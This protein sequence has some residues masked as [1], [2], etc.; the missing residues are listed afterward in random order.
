MN[1]TQTFAL[2][3]HI[4]HTGMAHH[5]RVGKRAPFAILLLLL[6]AA[7]ATTAQP[8]VITFRTETGVHLR[9][10][11][12]RQPGFAGYHVERKTAGGQWN[13]LTTTPLQRATTQQEIERIAGF[14]TDLYLTLFDAA[15]PPRDLTAAD[16]DRVLSRQNNGLFEAICVV[17]SEFG[18]LLGELY[19]DS[20]L[21]AGSDAEYR[22]TAIVGGAERELGISNPVGTE[23][24]T[25]PPVADLLGE[26]GDRS[27]T[28]RWERDPELQQQGQVI[29]WNIYRAENVLGPF[30]QINTT[31]L[32]PINVSSDQSP[33]DQNQQTF[34]DEYLE[35]G[36][37]YFYHIRA[38]NPFGIEGQPSVTVEITTG[39][40]EI[41]PP[42]QSIAVED[43]AGSARVTWVPQSKT[44]VAELR[45][46]RIEVTAQEKE[47]REVSP[48]LSATRFRAG[49]WVDLSVTEGSEYRY[50]ARTV[51]ANG[52]ESETSDTVSYRALDATPP[53]PPTGVVAV[54]DTGSITIRWE[55]NRER[56]LLGYQVERSSDDARISRLL[57]NDSIVAATS[58]VD[59]LPRQ[60]ET[61]YGYVVTAIDRSYNRSKPSAMIVARMPDV[62]PPTAPTITGLEVNDGKATLRWM[63]NSERDVARYRVYRSND[64][65]GKP[66]R[67]GETSGAEFTEPL[68]ADGRYFYSLSAVDSSGNEGGQSKPVPVSYRRQERPAPPRSV[69]VEPGANHLRIQWEAPAATVAG[70]VI[71]R[72][73]R[74]TGE[75]RTIAQP[76]STEREFKDWYVDP[77]G[78][79]EYTVQSRDAEW[80][81][82][83]GVKG[84]VGK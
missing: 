65:N 71:T 72:T 56:D 10:Q 40:G 12:V 20:T 14:K 80:R 39:S 11:G 18:K 22:I 45:V 17:N 53:A 34:S 46:Y 6:V 9:W 73:E 29:T 19:F 76:K 68:A 5:A 55:P 62:A 78:E 77:S 31:A 35:P 75:K 4:V 33:Q 79:Y 8:K 13:R 1:T 47:F 83:E 51:G 52:L 30:Q 44:G 25:I 67:V 37:T 64:A 58:I 28:L 23:P 26:P 41:P 54:A 24:D 59:R 15:K 21:P 7:A 57:L 32:L 49:E 69:T 3:A 36:K 27:A 63:P 82:S 84:K 61:A 60:S 43:F 42:P 50:F 38:V 81:L 48:A 66:Q 16:Y 74:K 2:A 70:Y